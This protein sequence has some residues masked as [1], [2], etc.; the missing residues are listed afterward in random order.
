MALSLSFQ[1]SLLSSPSSPPHYHYYYNCDFHH[2]HRYY[3]LGL[4][5]NEPFKL[6]LPLLLLS[7]VALISF[8]LLSFSTSQSFAAAAS[9][10]LSSTFLLHCSSLNPS[11][12]KVMMTRLHSNNGHF[13]FFCHYYYI[14]VIVDVLLWL[15][16]T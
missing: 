10:R 15:L 11:L 9:R 1:L 4:I 2:Y 3:C 5:S 16:V 13:Y 7:L 14:I 8:S 6:L 12:H